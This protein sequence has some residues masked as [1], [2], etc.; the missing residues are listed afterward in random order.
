[1]IEQFTR[2]EAA[3][4]PLLQP[5]IVCDADRESITSGA[6]VAIEESVAK[7]FNYLVENF[8]VR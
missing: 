6:S 3:Y 7:V 1:M 5:K 4:E 8:V 2:I